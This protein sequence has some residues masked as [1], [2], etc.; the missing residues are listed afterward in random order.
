MRRN[1]Q[2]TPVTNDYVGCQCEM[3]TSQQIGDVADALPKEITTHLKHAT[4]N[5]DKICSTHM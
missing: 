4:E 1:R 2:Q 5:S 3:T